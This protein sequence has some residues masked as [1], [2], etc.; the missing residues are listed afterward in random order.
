NVAGT[1]QFLG[2]FIGT[3]SANTNITL[4]G[5]SASILDES[6]LNG[7]RIFTSNNGNFTLKNAATLTVPGPFDNTGTLSIL[8][9]STFT[10]NGTISVTGNYT[11]EAAG[12]LDTAL[13][14]LATTQYDRLLVSGIASLGGTL[15]VSL[16][17]PFFPSN[18]KSFQVITGG[19]GRTN[20]FATIT[21]LNL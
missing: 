15:N 11:Q 3:V 9:T 12:I 16:I 5:P 10:S 21:G 17:S 19:G 4:D 14:G 13:G 18:A 7:L 2:A 1:F 8:D 6:S 20:T